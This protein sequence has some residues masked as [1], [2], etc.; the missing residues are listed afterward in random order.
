MILFPFVKETD[1]FLHL[2]NHCMKKL[3]FGD[4][5]ARI[6]ALFLVGSVAFLPSA[7][8]GTDSYRLFLDGK[9]IMSQY[10]GQPL[11][12]ITLP[13]P[14]ANGKG[15]LVI[16][17][18]HCG[19]TGKDRSITV[20]DEKGTV[21]KVW[22]FEDATRKEDGMHIPVKEL[23]ALEKTGRQLSLCYSSQQ[24]PEGRLLTHVGGAAKMAA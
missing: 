12:L 15:D 4:V 3:I 20:K 8:A 18:S 14:E 7:M 9:L 17:Y 13:L 1:F 6:L 24:L 16:Y 10:V 23:L 11:S 5:T 2:K 21:L 22:K 19:A